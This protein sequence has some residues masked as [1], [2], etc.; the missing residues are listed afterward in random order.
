MNKIRVV[1]TG[2]AA[3][4][5]LTGAVALAQG[6]YFGARMLGGAGQMAPLGGYPMQYNPYYNYDPSYITTAE[7]QVLPQTSASIDATLEKDS[8][9]LLKWSGE[10]QAIDW[11]RFTLLDTEKKV[12][13]EQKVDRPPAETRFPLTNKSAYYRVTVHYL[14][15]A[16]TTVTSLL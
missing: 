9:V 16:T 1:A 10:T 3:A 2:L 14:N 15:G 8:K 6:G 5:V 11:I 13:L 12:I 4:A 7:P